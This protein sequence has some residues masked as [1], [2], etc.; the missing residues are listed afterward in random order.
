MP[1]VVHAGGDATGAE[2]ERALMVAVQESGA[3]VHEGWL[4]TDLLVEHGRATGVIVRRR[5]RVPSRPRAAHT[6]IATGARAVLRGHHEPALS[7]GDGVAMALRAGVAVADLE[8][9]Q[10]HPTALHHPSMPRPLLSEA[11]RG[12]GAILRDDQGEAFMAA[13]HPLGDL[14]PRDVVARRDQPPAQRAWAR[15]PLARRHRHRRVPRAV[16]HDLA[17]L[18][19]RRSRPHAATG[20]RSRRR[21]TTC[22]VASAPTSTAPRRSPASGRAAKPRAP[23]STARTAWRRTR[24]W[25][26]WCSRPRVVEAI[27]RG[28]GR[29]GRH[30]CAPRHRPGTLRP[31]V[32]PAPLTRGAA[33]RSARSCSGS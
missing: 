17:G 32:V 11:L 21:R 16:P 6:V 29:A 23:A 30:R 8:F 20:C 25:R 19:E 18:P 27:A 3:E 14:A 24:C 15:P 1:R 5:R 9:M 12:E 33:C 4:A 7:T 26:T 28:Q 10:F 2:I 22:G 31:D 13:E